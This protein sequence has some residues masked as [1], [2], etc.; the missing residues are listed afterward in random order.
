MNILNHMIAEMNK[1]ELRFFKIFLSRTNENDDRKDIML[2]D[3]I[4]STAEKY[5]EEN[6]SRESDFDFRN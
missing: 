4:K 6:R 2:F 5:D 3:F 1:E